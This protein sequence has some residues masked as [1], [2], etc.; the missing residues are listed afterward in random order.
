MAADGGG[1]MSRGAEGRP[2]WG[3][4][5]LLA[6]KGRYRTLFETASVSLWEVD[7]TELERRL[8]ELQRDRRHDL[9]E[10]LGADPDAA[11]DLLSRLRVIDVNPAT[12]RLYGA[13]DKAQLL[14]SPE[15]L[16]GE[17]SMTVLRAGL[18]TID[19]DRR[20]LTAEVTTATFQDDRLDLL[21]GLQL[22]GPEDPASSTTLCAVDVTG[23]VREEQRLRE[24]ESRYR[25]LFERTAAA[26]YRTTVDGR[27]IDCNEAFAALLGFRSRE[28]ALEHPV[29]EF[30]FQPSDREA[31]LAR[32]RKHGRLFGEELTLRRSDGV[33]LHV[34][35]NVSL[36][37]DEA[38]GS[39]IL[40]GTMLDVT[41]S[42]RLQEQLI[43][44]QKLEAV[45]RLAGGIA[46]DFNNVLQ[47]M[48]AIVQLELEGVGGGERHLPRMAELEQHVRRGA[49]LARQLLLFSRRETT[50]RELIHLNQVIAEAARMLQRLVR[51]NIEFTVELTSEDLRINADQGQLEQVL[52]N[53]VVNAADAMPGGGRLTIRT[54]L[55]EGRAVLEVADTGNGIPAQALA[56]VFEPFF[57]TKEIGHGT[58]LGLAVVHG[59]VTAHAGEI[60]VES[61]LGT[62][63]VFRLLL[64]LAAEGV[65][66]EGL[67]YS[68]PG[69]PP[70]GYGERILVVEDEP[71]VRRALV[72]MLEGLGYEV[73]SAADPAVALDLAAGPVGFDLLLTD[74][75][76]PEMTG[77]ELATRLSD[78]WPGIGVILLSGYT[79]DP[80]V[81]PKVAAGRARVLQKPCDLETLARTLREVLHEVGSEG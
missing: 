34:V 21:L 24:S 73:E 16:F 53:L 75:I 7:P 80:A 26:M 66:G 42:H 76:M 25:L 61:T 79:P 78:R 40:D 71:A 27:L 77:A 41:E 46:H 4:E 69:G 35:E 28:E 30:Y 57:T 62:V 63:T 15:A 50:R 45:G 74:F 6:D 48:L 17:E 1:V 54:R 11:R 39:A 32:V 31:F 19:N 58:G 2:G 56:H 65:A 20:L 13:G 55:Q 47:A 22:P 5:G 67:E 64:P 33:P 38:G 10:L 12:L 36:M 44:S 14:G 60:E 70:R 9:G 18:T 49:Q 81:L 23:Q 51:E 59:I 8:A 72:T 68:R 37:E 3:P 43:R 52:M 29:T